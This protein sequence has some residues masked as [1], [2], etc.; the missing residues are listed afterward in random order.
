MHLSQVHLGRLFSVQVAIQEGHLLV[1]DGPY[2]HVRHPRYLGVL[3]FLPGIAL[4]FR[5]WVALAL[6]APILLVLLWRIADEEAL[7]RTTFGADWDAYARR[8]WRL[9]P[10]VW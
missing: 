3:L 4:V 1:T 7:M 9:V 8:T 6:A 5:S 2:R 10:L